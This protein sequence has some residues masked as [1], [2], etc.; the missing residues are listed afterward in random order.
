VS[1]LS[2]CIFIVYFAFDKVL[3]KNST[4][5]TNRLTRFFV[6]DKE[7]TH[8]ILPRIPKKNQLHDAL[9]N[10]RFEDASRFIASS[11]EADL[12]ESFESTEGSY[13][14]CLHIIAAISDTQVAT[15]L[16]KEL[17][18]RIENAMNREYLL[19]MRTVNEFDMI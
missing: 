15:N 19:N 3:L 5:T 11:S 12:V 16:C 7:Y 9:E 17:M 2:A 4:T 10:E 13:R 8:S 14:S 1:V 18:K 6:A